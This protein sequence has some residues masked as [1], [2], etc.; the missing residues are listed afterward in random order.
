ML[1]LGRGA[2]G[3]PKRCPM[4]QVV[5]YTPPDEK[6]TTLSDKKQQPHNQSAM[7]FSLL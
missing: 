5:P 4:R 1:A 3:K 2:G 7:V 6:N